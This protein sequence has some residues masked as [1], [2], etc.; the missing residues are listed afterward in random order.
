MRADG[1]PDFPDPGPGGYRRSG[2]NLQSPAV[3]SAMKACEKYLPS[4][5]HS[6]PVPADV[7]QQELLLASCMRTNGVPDFPD[8]NTNSDI[9]FPVDSPIPQSPAFQRAQNGPCKRYLSP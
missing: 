2:I 5:G 4:S 7:R 9:Q 3:A 6:P 1:V 8:P